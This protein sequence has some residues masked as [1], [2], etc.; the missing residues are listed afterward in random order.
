MNRIE[1]LEIKRRESILPELPGKI[2]YIPKRKPRDGLLSRNNV[3]G[4][5]TV[6]REK[7]DQEPHLLEAFVLAQVAGL[8]TLL[9]GP[10]GSGKT[11]MV[12]TLASAFYIKGRPLKFKHITVKEIHTE[13]N[14]F[15][16]P[17]FGA[18]AQGKEKW[19]PKLLDAEYAFI[20][21]IFRNH[22]IMAALN[23]VLEE[24]Q[25]EGLPLKWKFFVAA[26]NPPNAYYKTVDIL[27]M[28]DLDRFSV[29][30][31]VDDIGFGFA[32]KMIE[33]FKPE[34]DLKIDVSNLDEI[35]EE[36]ASTKVSPEAS[37]LAKMMVAAFSVCSYEPVEGKGL[38]RVTI[39]NKFGVIND[40]KCYRC[41]FQ[42]HSICPKYALA[43]KRALRSLIH[44]A[45]A[46]AWSLG[47]EVKE[48]DIVWAFRYTIPGRTAVI[49]QELKEVVPTYKVL[50]D[51]MLEDFR[52]WFE[53]MKRYFIEGFRMENDPLLPILREFVMEREVLEGY[54]VCIE[55]YTA[56]DLK[57][58]AKWFVVNK[59]ITAK[60]AAQIVEKL[61]KGISVIEGGL[62]LI[63]TNQSLAVEKFRD[64]REAEALCEFL[65]K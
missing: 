65:R 6:L 49:S 8:P 24:K 39:Y 56:E 42:Q 52:E 1:V 58:L 53:D 37:A 36:I 57:R 55:G 10:H 2:S 46:R 26:T 45:R 50:H 54:R 9:V 25:F 12:K 51:K 23:E 61:E 14:V 38:R 11:T 34:L 7:L 35:R 17:D 4:L 5:I 48:E 28:A 40:L 13:Y 30:V 19:I 3:L 27:N 16:R 41:V 31:E 44:L 64:R 18:L 29:I 20:D 21:E 62:N 15:A 43:P 32:D 33:G 22:R 47:R 63:P 60:R 59:G